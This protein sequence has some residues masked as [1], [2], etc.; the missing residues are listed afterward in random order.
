MRRELILKKILKSL[1]L[2]GKKKGCGENE[3]LH[4]PRFLKKFCGDKFFNNN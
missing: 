4:R 2:G 1:G 3:F